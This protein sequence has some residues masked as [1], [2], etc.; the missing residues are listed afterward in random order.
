MT[1]YRPKTGIRPI[2]DGRCGGIRESLEGMTMD[3]AERA[4]RL[5]GEELRIPVVV[6]NLPEESLIRSSA[7][8]AF[9]TY[10]EGS[11]FGACGNYGPLYR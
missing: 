9:D 4:A 6:L 1:N 5:Y 10:P 2:I 11:D 7:W 3:M 8:G